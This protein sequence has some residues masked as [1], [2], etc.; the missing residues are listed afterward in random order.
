MRGGGAIESRSGTEGAP[1]G[2]TG[3]APTLAA[4]GAVAVVWATGA[5]RLRS[6]RATRAWLTATCARAASAAAAWAAPLGKSAHSISAARSA[7]SIPASATPLCTIGTASATCAPSRQ[8][9]ACLTN[10]GTGRPRAGGWRR[11]DDLDQ[12]A[13]NRKR[14]GGGGSKRIETLS[15]WSCGARA[16]LKGCILCLTSSQVGASCNAICAHASRPP[17]T[18]EQPNEHAMV[19]DRI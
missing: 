6:S 4:R 1:P 16:A 11:G 8:A 12:R 18:M 9:R 7:T 13:P 10:G 19:H 15:L 3:T 14:H 17:A 2:G 5:C